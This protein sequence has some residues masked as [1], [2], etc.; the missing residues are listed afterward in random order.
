MFDLKAMI[1]VK[2]SQIEAIGYDAPNSITYVQFIGKSGAGS[3]S[4]YRYFNR[5][6]EEFD[7]FLA[8]PSKYGFFQ[9]HIKPT[10]EFEKVG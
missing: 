4:L 6:Q 2:S 8:A 1:P 7:K 10:K 5:S 9:V 3:G